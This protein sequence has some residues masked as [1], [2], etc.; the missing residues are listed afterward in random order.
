M[1][2]DF[3]RRFDR[4]VDIL[5]QLQSKRVI[6]AQELAD[7]FQ[8]SLRTIYRDIKS[9]EKAGVPIIGEAGAGYSIVDGYKLPPV[10]F[11]KEEALSFIGAEKLMERYMDK[12]M[13][14]N[15]KSAVYKV[16][17][18]LKHSEKE[19]ISSLENQI[20][21]NAKSYDIFNKDVPE[22]LSIFFKGI[23][24]KKQI[25]IQYKGVQDEKN[26]ARTVEPIGLYNDNG[27]WY[28]AAYCILRN[29]YRQFRADR[30]AAIQ[31][32]EKEFEEERISLDHYLSEIRK[33]I[34]TTKIRLITS[35][36][37]A[38]HLHWERLHFG[39]VEEIV[40]EDHIEMIFEYSGNFDYFARWFMMFADDSEI[41]EPIFLKSRVREILENSIM[42]I[43]R[44]KYQ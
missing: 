26:I 19:L 33:N 42:R 44:T 8:V 15:F 39:F 38:A 32:S 36:K 16:K 4:I 5:I 10:V 9:L 22:A 29:D 3:K 37:L 12:H 24:S 27:F 31:L 23:A 11:N 1:S 6:K 34:Q 25:N 13:I 21:L 7:R 40:K 30:I 18:V 17:S 35:F 43:R 20:H 28:I 41:I 2:N 14:S